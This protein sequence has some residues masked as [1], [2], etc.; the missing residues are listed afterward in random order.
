VETT[1]AV[2]LEMEMAEATMMLEMAAP[3][4]FCR[5]I[6]GT[7]GRLEEEGP[8]CRVFR[9]FLDLSRAAYE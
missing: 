8:G 9:A 6:E 1:D 7:D 5:R 2:D 4:V 3:F